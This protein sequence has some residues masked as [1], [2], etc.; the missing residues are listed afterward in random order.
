MNLSN[1][2]DST[3]QSISLHI[4]PSTEPTTPHCPQAHQVLKPRL[5]KKNIDLMKADAESSYEYDL[6]DDYA[7]S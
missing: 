2:D 1:E 7:L 4:R 5:N 3:I 6:S